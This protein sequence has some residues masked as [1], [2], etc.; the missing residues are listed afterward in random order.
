MSERARDFKLMYQ[1]P[2]IIG[3]ASLL[4]AIILGALLILIFRK[5]AES[6]LQQW[7]ADNRLRL[8]E[9]RQGSFSSSP[10]AYLSTSR[11]DHFF[12]IVVMTQTD[13][14]KSGWVRASGKFSALGERVTVIWDDPSSA[15]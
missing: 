6:N 11:D 15:G 2:P 9:Q 14:R 7:L 13:E 8:I 4:S 3:F 1:L 12:R 10:F 5:S